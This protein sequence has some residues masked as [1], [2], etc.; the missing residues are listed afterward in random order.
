[1]GSN[2]AD[3]MANMATIKGRIKVDMSIMTGDLAKD[4]VLWRSLVRKLGRA[5]KAWAKLEN[6]F[7]HILLVG[8]EEEAEEA[9]GDHKEFQTE[10][11]AL[12]SRVQDA[13]DK[14]KDEEEALMEADSRESRIRVLGERWLG[15]YRRI[16]AV[17]G[18]LQTRLGGDPIN[19]LDVLE[20]KSTQ[21]T[22]VKALIGSAATLVDAMLAADPDQTE[23][24][25][26][27]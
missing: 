20:L 5:E 25:L 13:I 8:S 14:A 7:V 12:L 27:V 24:T 9:C 11:F 19:S 23:V 16:D 3:V 2:I 18:E 6:H 15:T 1:M 22:E 17:L 26:E 4:R 10:L 21:V